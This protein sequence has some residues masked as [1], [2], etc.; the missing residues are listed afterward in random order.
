MQVKYQEPDYMRRLSLILVAFLTHFLELNHKEGHYF[1]IL[2]PVPILEQTVFFSVQALV[3]GIVM[4][5]VLTII[6]MDLYN[7]EQY[8]Y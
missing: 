5:F 6:Y 2:S 3:F 1:I 8:F 4:I 7:C